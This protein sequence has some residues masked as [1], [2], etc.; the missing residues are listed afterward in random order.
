[1]KFELGDFFIKRRFK[2]FIQNVIV[3][4]GLIVNR[5]DKIAESILRD[6]GAEGQEI[7]ILVT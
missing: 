7:S 5:I 1:M 3:P 6:F 2:S 4:D